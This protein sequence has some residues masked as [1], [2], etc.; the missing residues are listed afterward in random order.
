MVGGELQC[1]DMAGC[2]AK[3]H[4]VHIGDAAITGCPDDH[5]VDESGDGDE[6]DGMPEDRVMQADLGKERRD[7]AGNGEVASPG[8]DPDQYQDR[9]RTKMP[10]RIRSKMMPR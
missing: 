1:H 6:G 10:G 8:Q 5:E 2:P 4:R 3:G 9:P 7:L